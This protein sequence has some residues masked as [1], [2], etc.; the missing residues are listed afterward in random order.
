[1]SDTLGSR[2]SVDAR[3]VDMIYTIEDVPPW[4]LCVFLGL[5]VNIQ[6]TS[7]VFFPLQPS[8]AKLELQV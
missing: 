6:P 4:Y 5:Q 7:G 2:D 8:M 3:R 1:M